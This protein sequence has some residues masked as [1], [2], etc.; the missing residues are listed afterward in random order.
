MAPGTNRQVVLASRPTGP[1]DEATFETRAAPVP[2]PGDGE[3]LVRTAYVS[4]D[5]TMRGW[6]S[7][8]PS[9]MPPVGIGEVMRAGGNG[10]VVVSNHPAFRAGDLV[11]GMT[12]WQEY[13]V[14]GSSGVG[15]FRKLPA[16]MSLRHSLSVYGITGMTA[17]FGL[18][19]IGR[20]SAGETVVVSGAAGA[21]GS[22]AGQIA[23]I[24]GCRVIG[25]AGTAEKCAW[26]K[27]DLGFDECINYRQED[28]A[29]RLRETCPSGIDV[30]FDNVGGE[31]L[32]TVLLQIGMRARVAL[33]G[34]ISSG[35][36]EDSVPYGVRNL[37]MLIGL[38]ARMEGFLVIDYMDRFDEAAGVMRPWLAE[39][40]LKSREHVV[41]GLENCPRALRMLFEGANTGKLMV[42][43]GPDAA[44]R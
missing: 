18:I 24:L 33:C 1:V 30:Y 27:D 35:Y 2:E 40:K 29:R 17:Y 37:M 26:V 5:P 16:W 15:G 39:G 13:A 34:G 4:L 19:D 20:P 32:D 7:D 22:V 21:T 28:V 25:I 10:E 44:G 14:G 9:Y 12:G 31:T 41:E 23:K 6:I 11:Q 38:R 43:I 8:R 3:I 36:N 42:Q